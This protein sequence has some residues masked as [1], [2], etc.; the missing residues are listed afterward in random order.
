MKVSGQIACVFDG[1][2]LLNAARAVGT[3]EG[4]VLR[5]DG[6]SDGSFDG[7]HLGE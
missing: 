7:G 1:H 4:V 3:R 2:L 5:L 6:S